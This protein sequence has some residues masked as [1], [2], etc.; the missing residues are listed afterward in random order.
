MSLFFLESEHYLQYRRLPAIPNRGVVQKKSNI[1]TWINWIF[2]HWKLFDLLHYSVC[3]YIL[4]IY[5]FTCQLWPEDS[6]EVTKI[7][8]YM[9]MSLGVERFSLVYVE[10]SLGENILSVSTFSERVKLVLWPSIYL[11]LSTKVNPVSKYK[12]IYLYNFLKF[13]NISKWILNN[14]LKFFVYI[15]ISRKQYYSCN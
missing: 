2:A 15:T 12:C 4:F 7:I 8:Q 6:L 13:A 11:N 1:W 14:N 9:D 10:F 3:P 5:K